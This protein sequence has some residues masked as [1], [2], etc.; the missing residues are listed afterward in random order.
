MNEGTPLIHGEYAS[1]LQVFRDITN[2]T[3][4][5]TAVVD[6]IPVSG[7]GHTATLIEFKHARAIA[8]ALIMAN[9]NSIPFD[10]AA[11]ISV[12]GTHMSFFIVKQL[13]VLPPE[14]YLEEALCGRLYVELVVRRVLELTYT[15]YDLE[16]FA[17]DLGYNGP[18]F[19]WN[20]D[21][22]HRLKCELDAIFAHMYQLDRSDLEWIL[23]AQPPSTSFP[24]L[25]RN[26]TKEFGEYRTLRYVLQ[27]Y[28]QMA[29]GELPE[30]A[31]DPG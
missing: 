26:E 20:E 28:D 30:L 1:W 8:S 18:P 29:R 17:L 5:R 14:S 6:G 9:T 16:D 13:P 25:K 27:A 24:T 7:V 15:A 3:N 21:R 2:S 4:E 10:W 11:R 19:I 31:S 12:G 23:D 22:R